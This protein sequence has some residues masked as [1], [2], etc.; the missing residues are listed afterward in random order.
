MSEPIMVIFHKRPK[1]VSPKRKS[2]FSNPCRKCANT[3]LAFLYLE[4][5]D[6]SYMTVGSGTFPE[7]SRFTLTKRIT[8]SEVLPVSVRSIWRQN[9]RLCYPFRQREARG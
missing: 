9:F 3:L 2:F 7:P 4:G 5:I 8:Q 6:G 1:G